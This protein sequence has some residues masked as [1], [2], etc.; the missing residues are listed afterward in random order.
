MMVFD[1]NKGIIYQIL[2]VGLISLL[3]MAGTANISAAKE[4]NDISNEYTA[5]RENYPEK[6]EGNNDD[7]TSEYER[8]FEDEKAE[9]GME[10]SSDTA[11]TTKEGSH[12]GQKGSV[13]ENEEIAL[14]SMYKTNYLDWERHYWTASYNGSNLILSF[15]IDFYAI[16]NGYERFA[17]K[18]TFGYSTSSRTPSNVLS[19]TTAS[20]ASQ[21]YTNVGTINVTSFTRTGG[22]YP[23][24]RHLILK[25][26]ITVEA[27]RLS[28]LTGGR[29]RY[30]G[31]GWKDGDW[32]AAE[33]GDFNV[34]NFW[35]AYTQAAC[36]HSAW[37]YNSN[38]ASGHNEVCR[39]CGYTRQQSHRMS[40]GA[41]TACG[42]RSLVNIRLIYELNGR[43]ESEDVSLA[44]GSSY[45]PKTIKG[46][47]KPAAL[48]VPSSGGSINIKYEPI[49]YTVST[50]DERYELKYDES[51][52]LPQ[53]ERKGYVHKGY[54]TAQVS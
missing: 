23:Y 11:I 10:K 53:R 27:K 36:T 41:C 32:E 8:P 51:L 44:P 28:S 13:P 24:D 19:C 18:Y 38:G 47:R 35:A 14:M 33:N 45:Q 46:Y 17:P 52:F 5:T 54:V 7:I 30:F 49:I 50:E 1:M 31:G 15:D 6:P 34:T 42:Y 3:T 22:E 39:A 40:N 26:Y 12:D 2:T 25:G 29:F 37:N 20:N 48:T 21:V 43:T 16:G 9:A 4:I